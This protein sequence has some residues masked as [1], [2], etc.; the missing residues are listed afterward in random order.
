MTLFDLLGSTD[1]TE[2][3]SAL[4]NIEAKLA[5]FDD[6]KSLS[7]SSKILNGY[8]NNLP[9]RTA[10]TAYLNIVSGL[11]LGLGLV[12]AGSADSDA[13]STIINKLQLFQR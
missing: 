9:L 8:Q 6:K 5:R 7:F 1:V 13:K 10:I 11:C 3:N 4:A 2:Q 12:F